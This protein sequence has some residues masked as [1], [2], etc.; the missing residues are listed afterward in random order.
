MIIGLLGAAA[1]CFFGVTGVDVYKDGELCSVLSDD[2]S[3]GF[4]LQ[5]TWRREVQL[6]GFGNAE[7]QIASDLDNVSY[8]QNNQLYIMPQLTSDWLGVATVEGG[9]LTMDPCTE[10]ETNKT[11]CTATANGVDSV[12]NP[13]LSA[14]ISTMGHYDISY[15]RVEVRAKLPRGDWLWPAIW[16]LPVNGTWPM[17]GELDIMEARGN[18]PA[19][20]GQGSNYVRSTVQY[21]P[22]DSVLARLYGWY[23]LKRTSFD[24]GF[25]TYGL[26]WSDKW[27]RFYVDSRVHSTLSLSTKNGKEGFWERAGF[28]ATA[29]NGSSQVVVEKPAAYTHNSSPFDKPFYL[30]IDL[31]VGGTSGWFPD[32]VGGKPWFDGSLSAMYDFWQAKDT[33]YKTWPTSPADRAFRIDS[34]KMWKKC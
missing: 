20:E 33:W 4:D 23:G 5:N 3:K 1:L 24:K 9:S 22:M 25:H 12:V 7:F 17:S 15:G 14:R 30:I 29:Q 31:A 13:V 28:P 16:M 27:M 6:G 34:V 18:S 11:A 2:F 10:S 26:E 19:Y 21:G 8:V 32:K